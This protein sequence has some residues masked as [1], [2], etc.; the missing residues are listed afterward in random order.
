VIVALVVI[1]TVFNL[2]LPANAG[3]CHPDYDVCR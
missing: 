1:G 2:H 3:A